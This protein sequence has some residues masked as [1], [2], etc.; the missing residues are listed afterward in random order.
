MFVLVFERSFSSSLLCLTHYLNL[1]PFCPQIVENQLG[2]CRPFGVYP[3][4]KL[5][6]NI[7]QVL[8]GLDFVMLFE[9]IP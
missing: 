1:D 4:S 2:P 6:R 8:S 9:E 7:C 3:P 5:H